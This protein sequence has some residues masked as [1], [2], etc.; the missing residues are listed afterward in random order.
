MPV[1]ATIGNFNDGDARA[2]SSPTSPSPQSRLT[3]GAS[4]LAPRT[5]GDLG[6]RRVRAVTGRPRDTHRHERSALQRAVPLRPPAWGCG[7]ERPEKYPGLFRSAR[8]PRTAAT[9]LPAL[10][11]SS[12]AA[13]RHEAR[14]LVRDHHLQRTTRE[15]EHAPRR[16]TQ[17]STRWSRCSGRGCRLRARAGLSDHRR[18][19]GVPGRA[20]ARGRYRAG[21]RP[22]R[23]A[24][25][26]TL[27]RKKTALASACSWSFAGALRWGGRSGRYWP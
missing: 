24:R 12:E 26:K 4:H 15:P 22:V 3:R 7:H 17:G 6:L 5:R 19:T 2:M 8:P 20:R 21:D 16:S 27:K 13:V 18:R 14:A 10:G 11:A 23:H 9:D 25:R 1:R